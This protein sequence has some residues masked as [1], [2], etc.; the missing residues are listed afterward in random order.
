[1]E[2]SSEKSDQEISTIVSGP[3]KEITNTIIDDASDSSSETTVMEYPS[4]IAVNVELDEINKSDLVAADEL[5]MPMTIDRLHSTDDKAEPNSMSVNYDSDEEFFDA[6]PWESMSK[7]HHDRNP[8]DEPQP[9]RRRS[10]SPSVL[11]RVCTY[12][13]NYVHAKGNTISFEIG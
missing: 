4:P 11:P 10:D 5:L 8:S 1:M 3:S 12:Q 13:K 6:D 7:R 9:K 2:N